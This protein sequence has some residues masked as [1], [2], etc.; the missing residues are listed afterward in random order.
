MAKSYPHEVFQKAI[1]WLIYEGKIK[2][3]KDIA[4][5]VGLDKSTVS[6]YLSGSKKASK[7]FVEKFEGAFKLSLHD[8]EEKLPDTGK[9]A[10]IEAR[11]LR[12][13][14]NAEVF[15]IAIAGL[16]AKKTDDF[17]QRFSELQALIEE[18]VKRR[19]KL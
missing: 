5:A 13:E 8:F 12:L 6:T 7:N 16:K 14:A 17:G 15:Q 18:A 9:A 1:K 10:T 19:S 11:L 3:D 4:G 2:T